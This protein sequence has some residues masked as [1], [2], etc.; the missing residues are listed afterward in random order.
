MSRRL[1]IGSLFVFGL[2]VMVIR[3]FAS[4]GAATSQPAPATARQAVAEA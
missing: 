2:V 4:Q 3:P 1:V